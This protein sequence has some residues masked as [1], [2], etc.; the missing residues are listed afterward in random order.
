MSAAYPVRPL[1]R[2]REAWAKW[3]GSEQGGFGGEELEE[4][5]AALPEA[6]ADIARLERS[7][8]HMQDFRPNC[9]RAQIGTQDGAN[10]YDQFPATRCLEF[11]DHQRE[12]MQ[13]RGGYR[14]AMVLLEDGEGNGWQ[15]WWKLDPGRT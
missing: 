4:L 10:W 3:D 8:K 12:T 7:L 5:L 15:G 14:W 2:L 11:A 1:D 6:V 13:E 9:V